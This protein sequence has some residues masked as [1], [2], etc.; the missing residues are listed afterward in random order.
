[1]RRLIAL[2]LT[3]LAIMPAAVFGQS[4]IR[5]IVIDSLTREPM[6][7]ATVYVNGTTQG[8]STDIDGRFELKDVSLPATV[9]FSFVGY[10]TQALDLKRNPGELKVQLKTNDELPEVLVSAKTNS[11]DKEALEFFRKMFLGDDKWGQRAKIK[12]ENVIMIDDSYETSSYIRHVDTWRMIGIGNRY[13]ETVVEKRRIFTAWANEPLI[14]DLPLL[15]YEVYVDLV[16]FTV[17]EDGAHTQSDMLGFFY[18]KPYEN[19]K[20]I[21]A[22]GFEKNRQKAYYGSSQHF[23]R[24]LA[25]D[26]LAENG[27]VLSMPDRV[28]KGK[29]TISTYNPV[30]IGK[31]L[32]DLGHNQMQIKG[33][34]DKKLRI[35]YYHM[36][37]GS[38]M[39][40]KEK[41]KGIRHYSESWMSFLKDTCI[42][43]KEGIFADNSIQLMGDQSKRM[44]GSYLPDDYFPPG[45]SDRV[46]RFEQVDYAAELMKFADNV[47][48]FNSMFPQEK[49]YLE[50]DNTAY[51][52]GENIWFKAFVTH[53]TTLERAP[54]GVLYVD[55]LAPT[56]Q[57]IL[58]Q[59]LKIDAGQADGAIALLDAGTFQTREKYGVRAYPS[60]FYEIRAYTQNML[61]FSPE[62]IFSRVIPIYTQPK[63]VGEYDRSHVESHQGNPL[64]DKIRGESD[65][66]YKKV[67]VTFY[68]EGGDLVKG[69]PCRVAFKATGSDGFGIE[70][71]LAVPGVRDSVRTVH[72]GMGS[73]I[74]T[75][76]GNETAEFI[77][78]SGV[79]TINLPKPLKSG[80]SMMVDMKPDSHMQVNIWRTP[81][82]VG[83]ETALAV[84]C[85]GDVIY[86]EQIRDLDNSQLE[87]DCSGWPVGV[88][89]VTLFDDEGR[90]LSSRSI[91]NGS[92]NLR[93]PSIA[94]N[95]DSMSRQSCEKEVIELMLTDQEGN[96]FRDRFCLS[97]RDATDY[98]GGLT[99]NLQ[100]NL[101]LLSD[102]RGYI[103]DPAWYL[104]S[105]DEEHREALNLLTLV[106]GWER[107]EWQT[108]AGLKEFEEKHRV[109]EGL[110]MNG[111]ILSY[112]RR[113]PVSDIGVYA[114]V[115][116]DDDKTLFES[117][118]Y[119]TDSTGYFGFNLSDFYG[120]GKFNINLMS[121]KDNGDSK[122]EKSKRIRFERADRP[123]PRPFL[124]QEMDLDHN[125][126]SPYDYKVDYTDFDLTP[127]Q[128]S[129]LG[130]MIDDVDIED[131]G[132][133]QR[134]VDFDTFTSF[135]AEEDSELELDQGE[136]T[137]NL[138][139]YFLDKGIKLTF[140]I[141]REDN[142]WEYQDGTVSR[143]LRPYF[144]VHNM[145][146][147]LM[148]K[149]FDI[150]MG[151]DMIDVK[152]VILYDRPMYPREFADIIPLDKEYYHI[153]FGAEPSKA[154]V[155]PIKR[156]K[157]YEGYFDFFVWLSTCMDKF[158]LV[159]VQIKEDRELLFYDEIRNLGRRTTTVKGFTRPV[160]FYSPEYP[161]GPIEGS[162]DYRRTLY[163]NPNVITDEDGRARVEFYNNSFS[164][165]FTINAAGITA[166]G[167]PYILNENW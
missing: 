106:Q 35:R 54:S 57:L 95:T 60:G 22:D 15:G 130:R 40:F 19:V 105:D 139:G 96:P 51:F 98:G 74:I 65:E 155:S 25:D 6:P 13:D 144:Y 164:R 108:M 110:T 8:T 64:M 101:L 122:Y 136:F 117:F 133:K 9:V 162:P 147:S 165:K 153:H 128:R 66:K 88:C 39:N 127:A 102:L 11:I 115:M 77:V 44:V 141:D 30:D 137:T 33:L 36:N 148:N 58:Q 94:L 55:F 119:Q 28:V 27:Y 163:W 63:Y 69:L 90:V 84:T 140:E 37:D 116:P 26:R 103:H 125:N 2:T 49:V 104:E 83:Q 21:K 89:R 24:S 87:I 93:S 78:P 149:P 145:Q 32:S 45:D 86:F 159:D 156:P 52:Q 132:Q 61:D 31:Y 12:N 157:D 14:V 150:P 85:R 43:L 138:F 62:A 70:G 71:A 92:G 72:D 81:D 113:D 10:R 82:L 111:W 56:G 41:G 79:A 123:V 7:L 114:N 3:L 76:K 67:N 16:K 1:M 151:I 135:E 131:A 80:Y 142:V 107:Y 143:E 48:Q 160:Q 23:L 158:Y 120:K 46:R 152:S 29:R 134:F 42:F 166:S 68:P 50:F 59:K 97:V 34:D 109:E 121:T 167:I 17:I 4:T 118:D 75:P 124:R 100:T 126:H 5:G 161:D 146:R 47:Q 91:F 20:K 112:G 38:P 73:F 129:R 154:R 53:A 18:Y 99:D